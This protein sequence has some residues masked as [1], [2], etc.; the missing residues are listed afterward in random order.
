M[1]V[2]SSDRS[3]RVVYIPHGGGPL[4]LFGDPAHAGLIAFL[5]ALPKSLIRKPTAILMVSAHWEAERPTLTSAARQRLLYD[6]HGFS[7]EAYEVE[8]PAVGAPELASTLQALLGEAGF[9]ADL[10]ADRGFDHGMFVPLKLM[11]PDAEI[12]CVQLSLMQGLDPRAHIDLGRAIA[13]I[14]GEEILVIG[15]GLSFH[16]MQAM[17]V[18]DPLGRE[19]SGVFDRWLT[20]TCTAT[21]LTPVDRQR[22]LIAWEEEAPHARFCHPREEHLLPLHVCF[23]A[24]GMSRAQIAYEGEFAG[25]RISGF[26]W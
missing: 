8:Y 26:V 23:G 21:G 25:H 19:K 4:P 17:V 16:N 7:A 5:G 24:A 20:Q 10:D 2:A 12:P 14:P 11:Y 6:Y 9:S 18:A 1:T 3:G 15:S 22:R 13:N